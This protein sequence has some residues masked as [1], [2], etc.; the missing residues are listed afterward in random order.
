MFFLPGV[1]SLS[2]G[3]TAALSR[4]CERP[5]SAR[6]EAFEKR[7][8]HPGWRHCRCGL[9]LTVAAELLGVHFNRHL[10]FRVGFRDI[11]SDSFSTRAQQV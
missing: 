9:G 1:G 2:S 4:L 3:A 10:G 7:R 5:C 6:R 11:F 8:P